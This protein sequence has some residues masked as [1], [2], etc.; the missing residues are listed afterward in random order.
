MYK[1]NIIELFIAIII[2][3]MISILVTYNRCYEPYS[4]YNERKDNICLYYQDNICVK[5]EI[6][7]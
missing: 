3:S 4:S 2:S 5:Y 6:N 7:E 1:F